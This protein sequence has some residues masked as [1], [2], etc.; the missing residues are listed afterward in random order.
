MERLVR[1]CHAHVC[2]GMCLR[3]LIHAH[4]DV[5]MAPKDLESLLEIL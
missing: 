4:K 3:A 1:G 5:S 2:V